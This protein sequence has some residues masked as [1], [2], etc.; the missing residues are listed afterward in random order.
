MSGDCLILWGEWAGT[1]I[2]SIHQ[3]TPY[4]FPR[5]QKEGFRM[6]SSADVLFLV[7]SV[8]NILSQAYQLAR[9]RLAS[10]ASPVLRL[11]VQ[12]D[13]TLG[14]LELLRRELDILRAQRESMP[15]HQRPDYRPEQRLAILQLRRLRGWSVAQT[16]QRLVLHPNTLC[17]WIKALEGD[18]STRL[19]L[20]AIVWNR[21]D[22]AVRWASHELRRL[23]PEPEFGTRAIARHLVRAGVAISHS[24]VQRVLRESK[25]ARPP[26]CH[27]P[28]MAEPEGEEPYHLLIPKEP[29]RV[30]HLDL[31]SLRVLWL[32]FTVAAILDGFSRKLLAMKVFVNA[33]HSS[34]M[35]R[36]V[37]HAVNQNGQPRFLITDHGAQFRKQ[38]HAA[39]KRKG[40]I[41]VQGRVRAPYLNGKIERVFRTF[42]IWWRVILTGFTLR[43][44]Q[45]RLD[46]Y[47]HWYNHHRP[48]SALRGLT[49]E[50]AWNGQ[51]LPAAQSFRAGEP[52]KPHI[53]IRRV[54]CRGDP[55]LPVVEIALRKAA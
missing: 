29:N 17:S 41:H 8:A 19:F 25:P 16:A 5:T 34:D 38:F 3:H 32:R 37:H 1:A 40:V 51:S 50:E 53:R 22:D 11:L 9:A 43:H 54:H 46:H 47:R 23:C 48:H 18:G 55:H 14:E 33:P 28:A 10:A 35:A 44:V 52:L 20:G 39:M 12:R 30:W 13:Q 45:H 42:K 15:P 4:R 26:R 24:T 36:L 7:D 27:R 2:S 6:P 21:I 31:T 49:P